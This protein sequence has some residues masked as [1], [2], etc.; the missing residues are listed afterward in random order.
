MFNPPFL[1]GCVAQSWPHSSL[2]PGLC[3]ASTEIDGKF[4]ENV[5]RIGER[6]FV[7]FSYI[8]NEPTVSMLCLFIPFS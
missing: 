4:W 1:E 7:L 5:H 2:D 6:N 8:K 3:A